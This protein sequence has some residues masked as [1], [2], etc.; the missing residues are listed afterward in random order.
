[1][2]RMATMPIYGKTLLK[3]FLGT[4]RLMALKLGMQYPMAD[5]LEIWYAA[6]VPRALSSLF[7]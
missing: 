7:K 3:I 5:G 4:E 2:T 6:F 1:M